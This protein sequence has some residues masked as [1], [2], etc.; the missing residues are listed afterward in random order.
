MRGHGT[1]AGGSGADGPRPATT[2]RAALGLF[3]AGAAGLLLP[4]VAGAVTTDGLVF[5]IL[6]RGDA[7]GEHRVTFGPSGDGGLRVGT[8]IEVTVRLAFVTLYSFRE[9]VDAVWRN[10]RMTAARIEIEDQ[11]DRREIILARRD[12]ILVAEGPGGIRELPDDC[13]TDIDFWTPEITR[14]SRVLDT[15]TGEVVPLEARPGPLETLRLG[16]EEVA[17]RRFSLRA[18]RG[19][20][21]DVWYTADG[22][23]V[24]GRLK[25][26]GEDLEYLPIELPLPAQSGQT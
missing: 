22:I 19:R 5:R 24:R 9:R 12:G 21:G 18:N 3:A 26:R 17:A 2:R 11:G 1:S 4:R 14:R 23:W 10:G 20:S 13:V 7:I 25:T 15:W 8:D 6:R 16:R